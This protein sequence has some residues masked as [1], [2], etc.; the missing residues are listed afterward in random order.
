MTKLQMKVHKEKTQCEYCK[1]EFDIDNKRVAHHNH[2]NGNFI[3]TTCLSCN[4]K[5]KVDNCLYIVFHYIKG[6]DGNFNLSIINEHLKIKQ[7]I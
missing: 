7:L 6:Y 4:S 2:L 1:V 5:M 3:A